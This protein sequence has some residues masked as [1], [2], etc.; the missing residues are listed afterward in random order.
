MKPTNE[1]RIEA[2]KRIVSFNTNGY[3]E[4]SQHRIALDIIAADPLTAYVESRLALDAPELVDAVA[5]ALWDCE[6]S[7]PIGRYW[8]ISWSEVKDDYH[9]KITRRMAAAAIS[10]IKQALAGDK[11]G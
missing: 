5:E 10:T 7:D 6:D 11:G 4:E 1:Q 9:I 3:S 2:I 8:G